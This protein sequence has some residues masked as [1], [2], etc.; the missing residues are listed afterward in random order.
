[1]SPL[2]GVAL[3]LELANRRLTEPED[4]SAR[5]AVVRASQTLQ[6]VRRFVSDLLEFAR[7]GARP[8]PGVRAS[9]EDTIRE[10]AEEFG[11]LAHDAGVELCV[12]E[13][14]TSR[15]VACSPGVLSS[16]LSNLV[17]NAI[18]YIGDGAERRVSIRSVDDVERVRFE[19]EDTGPGISPEDRGSL[20][21]PYARGKNAKVPGHGLGLATVKRLVESHGGELGVESAKGRGSV[22]WFSMPAADRND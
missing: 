15:A 10:I 12:E 18:K 16:A 9:V 13:A 7:A 11:P 17:Q 5:K 20:F 22:F 8:L 14:S 3:A 6:R 19:V 1:M 4:A 21:E 2:A